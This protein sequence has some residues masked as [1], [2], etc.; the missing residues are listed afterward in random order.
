MVFMKKKSPHIWV[1][2]TSSPIKSINP[3]ATI[4]ALSFSLLQMWSQDVV[5]HCRQGNLPQE[6]MERRSN[7]TSFDLAFSAKTWRPFNGAPEIG[8]IE[9]QKTKMMRL[10][11]TYHIYIYMI[12][13][14]IYIYVLPSWVSLCT[15]PV[16]SSSDSSSSGRG[17]AAGAVARLRLRSM[18]KHGDGK[19][20]L[21]GGNCSPPKKKDTTM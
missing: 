14:Y 19:W 5:Q 16:T 10:G 2:F 9:K 11:R 13:K 18:A 21:W 15:N 8:V 1:G 3:Q 12:C 20:S 17:N 7:S 4:W 6:D